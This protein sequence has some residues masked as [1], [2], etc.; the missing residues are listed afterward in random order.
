MLSGLPYSAVLVMTLVS[1]LICFM[2]PPVPGVPVYLFAGVLVV[3]ESPFE[4][5][6]SCG[7]AIC[8]GYVLKL[9]ACAMQ[10]KLIGELLGHSITVKSQCGI[11]Q[12][13]IRA[14]EQVL[15]DPSTFA[16]GKV[17][18]LCGGPDWP[19][20]VMAGLLKLPLLKMELGTLP[21][22]LFIAPCTLSGAFYLK[23]EESA[24][25]SRASSLMIS[26]TLLISL[27]MWVAAAWAIQEQL[28]TNNWEVTRPLE[29][30][31][32][33]DF[34]DYRSIQIRNCF[35]VKWSAHDRHDKDEAV[36]CGA[37]RAIAVV[38]VVLV[39]GV[40][41]AFYWMPAR[42]FGDFAVT[43]D[44]G[45][46][47]LYGEDGGL[48]KFMGAVRLAITAVGFFGYVILSCYIGSLQKQAFRTRAAELAQE[49]ADW[50]K[51]RMVETQQQQ[52]PKCARWREDTA[53]I[54]RKRLVV[55]KLQNMGKFASKE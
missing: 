43:D 51:R 36:L 48:V 35:P 5:W 12:P 7:I 14:I 44:I 33:L 40:G 15:R 34:L 26:S 10:Q 50:K 20:S 25:W 42:C 31:I 11:N 8:I 53:L 22:I 27:S 16:V 19:T 32:D 4:F 1:G 37:V 47:K 18:I 39:V 21:I 6:P 49:E 41:H 29:K 23:R 9:L 24:F 13:F 46:F 38:G 30:N 17:A 52:E 55:C 28:D 2:L 3:G 45:S 54:T